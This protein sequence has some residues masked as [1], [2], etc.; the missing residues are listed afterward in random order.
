M[1]IL[2]L[3]PCDEKWVHAATGIF[4]NLAPEVKEVAYPIPMYMEYLIDTRISKNWLEAFFDAQLSARAY[5]DAAQKNDLDLLVIGNVS[6]EICGGP[7]VNNTRELGHFKIKKEESS[8][9]G[10]RRIKAILE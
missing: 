7:H 10:V 4:K 5:C 6:K 3:M 1:K 8:S 9:A 2:I